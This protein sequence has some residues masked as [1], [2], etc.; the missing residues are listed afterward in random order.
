MIDAILDIKPSDNTAIITETGRNISYSM[1]CLDVERIAVCFEPGQLVFILCRNDYSSVVM[2]LAAL[3]NRAIPLLLSADI[4]E[5]QLIKLCEIY[6]PAHIAAPDGS[7]IPDFYSLRGGKKYEHTL[8]TIN[9]PSKVRINENLALLMTTSG[10]TGDPKLVRLSAENIANNVASIIDYL[11]ISSSDRAITTL[12]ISYSYGL[13]VLHTHLAAGGS[14][15]L[16]N[17]SLMEREFWQNIQ[18]Y[19]VTCFSGVPYH[20]EM[21]LRLGLKRLKISSI[22][23]MTQA[24]G[25]L[26]FSKM[27]QIATYCIE[28][29]ITFWTMYG[30]TEA[31][32]RISYVPS[33]NTLNK[34]NSIGIPILGGRM[35]IS[36]DDGSDITSTGDIGELVYEGKNVCMGYAH[37][38]DDLSLGDIN[39]QVLKTGDLAR[40]D[41]DG[42]FY[43]MGRL[44]RFIK[45]FGTRISLDQLE[46]TVRNQGYDTVLHG[47][48]DQLIAYVVDVNVSVQKDIKEEISRQSGIHK[49]AIKVVNVREIPLLDTGKIDY[50][51]LMKMS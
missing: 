17:H 10:S 23:K 36:N 2:Y 46:E 16:T 43:I 7:M 32:P 39:K 29:N 45:I 35:W 19:S 50:Q 51:C 22:T 1:L 37:S 38:R 31:S 24:G 9:V 18:D 13:S 48:D 42:Y 49:T 14:I 21:L 4:E 44:K 20:Y 34:P 40:C 8:Y 28:K 26:D 6:R 47:E 30:Q 33:F 5:K 15:V 41:K 3:E 12:P 11:S 25:H 27:K